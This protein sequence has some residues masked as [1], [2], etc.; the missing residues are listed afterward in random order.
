MLDSLD[1]AMPSSHGLPSVSIGALQLR[2]NTPVLHEL[3]NQ[4]VPL[5]LKVL[6]VYTNAIAESLDKSEEWAMGFSFGN[7]VRF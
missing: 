5:V 4:V 7:S 2:D 6:R 3:S 1:G